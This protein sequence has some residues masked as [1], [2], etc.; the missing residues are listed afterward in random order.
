MES[1]TQ[2]SRPRPRTQ[3]M[4]EAKDS[5]SENRPSRGQGHERSR[6]RTK[7]TGA[8]ELQKKGLQNFFQAFSK[9]KVF[10]IIFQAIYK[11]LTIHKILPSSSRGQGNFRG[12]EASRPR[13]S[14]RVLVDVLE[15]S[16]SDADRFNFF[17]FRM[18]ICQVTKLFH[19]K[20]DL[21]LRFSLRSSL[22][23]CCCVLFCLLAFFGMFFK[24]F[25][26][27]AMPN[28]CDYKLAII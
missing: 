2:S 11:I 22:I 8:S 23:L 16:T 3:K 4:S 18:T 1:R 13:I 25:G 20:K 10:K 12:L 9:K 6:P 27:L 5:P 26:S 14:K 21:Y 7:D 24:C 19:R 28:W 15:D 17:F